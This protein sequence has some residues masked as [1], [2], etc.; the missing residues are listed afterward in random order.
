MRRHDITV[1]TLQELG[2]LGDTDIN[3]LSWATEMDCVLCTCDDHTDEN[4]DRRSEHHHL[5]DT[6]DGHQPK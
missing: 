2:L 3:H 5:F 6:V 1:Y 4:P